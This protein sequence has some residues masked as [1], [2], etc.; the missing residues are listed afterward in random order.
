MS[1]RHKSIRHCERSAAIQT[2]RGAL[3]DCFA[4]LAMTTSGG[5]A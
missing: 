3:L 4:T 5:P 1:L 2:A